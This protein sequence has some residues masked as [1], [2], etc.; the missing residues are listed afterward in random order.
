MR[1]INH[2]WSALQDVRRSL[3]QW[4]RCRRVHWWSATI[5]H[6]WENAQYQEKGRKGKVMMKRWW[7]RWLC[8]F[9][10]A[11]WSSRLLPDGPRKPIK[12]TTGTTMHHIVW[13]SCLKVGTQY[14]CRYHLAKAP[15]VVC[16]IIKNITHQTK[17]ITECNTNKYSARVNTRLCLIKIY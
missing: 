14:R 1:V 2:A 17:D 4:W 12:C 3:H 6:H 15:V 16:K 13:P 9:P 11:G 10:P 5:A 8:R 7:Q